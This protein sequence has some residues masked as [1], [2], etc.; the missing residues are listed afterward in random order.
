M[1]V[2]LERSLGQGFRIDGR[3]FVVTRVDA[4]LQFCVQDT[5]TGEEWCVTDHE[6]QEVMPG[7][8]VY[9]G[10][11]AP[12]N[13]ARVVISAPPDFVVVRSEVSS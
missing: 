1:P 6:V 8:S 2:M 10:D 11:R 7:V 13:H 3:E 5:T 9:A 4:P 12:N